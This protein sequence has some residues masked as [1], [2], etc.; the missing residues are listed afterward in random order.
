[1]WRPIRQFPSQHG[2]AC[3]INLPC[4][5]RAHSLAHS[6]AP[7]CFLQLS[8]VGLIVVLVPGCCWACSA[9]FHVPPPDPLR[10]PGQAECVL[11]GES[12]VS[13]ATP[14]LNA[15]CHRLCTRLTTTHVSLSDFAKKPHCDHEVHQ[16]RAP[17][18]FPFQKR[19]SLDIRGLRH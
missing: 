6:S 7:H 10:L 14:R 19:P 4:C 8:S 17:N 12:R 5:P 3:N 1:M 18:S 13:P 11:H 9:F 2:V 16:P 15:C